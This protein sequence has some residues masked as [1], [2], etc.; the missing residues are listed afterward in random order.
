MQAKRQFTKS[1]SISFRLHKFQASPSPRI[2]PN[3][4]PI[5]EDPDERSPMLNLN[6]PSL[7][8]REFKMNTSIFKVSDGSDSPRSPFQILQR[9]KTVSFQEDTPS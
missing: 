7:K 3:D 5:F 1:N 8:R 4:D 6:S 9:T 2:K